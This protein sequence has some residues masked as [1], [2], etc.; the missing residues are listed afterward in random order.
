MKT[1]ELKAQSWLDGDFDQSTKMQILKLRA[2]DPAGFEDAFYKNLEFGTGGLRGIM[3]VG[4]NR[5]NKYTVG[6]ATQG[7]A[8]YIL[9]HCEGSDLRVVISYDSR[10][11]S[12]EFAKIAAQVLSANGIHVFIFDNIRPT[13][14]MSY[15]VRLKKAVAG[16]MITASHN[17]KEYNGYKVSWSDGGQ[18]TSPVDKEIVAEVAKITDPSMVKFE[19]GLRCGEIESMG[20]DVDEQY[21]TDLLSLRLSP[22]AA[23]TNGDIKIVYTPLHGCGV[24]LVPEILRR[25]GFKNVIH[26]PEQDISDGD[27]PTCVSPNPEEPAALKLALEKAEQTGADLVIGTDPD[28]DRVG[29][30]V[31]NDEGKLVLLNGNQTAS[32][33]T[34][35]ILSRRKE[36]GTLGKGKYVVKTIVT[37][38]LITE[39]CK[40]FDVPVYNV[41]TGFKYIAAVIKEREALGEEFLCG[42]EESYGFNIGQFVRDKDAPVTCMMVAECAAWAA[43]KGLSMYQLLQKIYAEYGYRKEGLVS[44]VRKGI[45]GTREIAAIMEGL[46]AN[47]PAELLGSPV[48]RVVDYL[49]PELTGQPSS[50]VLQFF[51]E[52]GDVVSVRPSGTEPKIKFYFGAKGADADDKIARL[53]EQFA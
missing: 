26:V 5:M 43:S 40:S 45:E 20:A 37:T 34:W 1:H 27:F 21:L 24:R 18:V 52:A 51:D 33:L 47:P 36:L 53:K 23:A 13:P 6:M 8:N 30:A 19:A 11:N 42:G 12:K 25:A 7:L 9:Q 15:A 35:Y 28:A 2:E 44:L 31:R 49:K 39:I 14:E 41:L 48:T 46:R 16:I 29:I 22:E 4:T 32:I 38:E 3:G 17:P 10:N 50:N